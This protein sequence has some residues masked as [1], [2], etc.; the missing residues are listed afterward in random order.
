M[1]LKEPESTD[2]LLYYTRRTLGDKG[3]AVA[4]VYK[5]ECPKCHKARMGKPADEKGKVKI[6]AN[7]YVCPACGY[8]EDKKTHEESCILQVK[9][10]CP[11]CSKSGEAET[12]YKRTSFEGS[13]AYV[14]TCPH[15]MKKIGIT[16]KM[17]S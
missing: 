11:F 4:W 15:C 10:V 5:K 16:K 12:G 3:K 13:P 6:R 14:F 1:V 8:S 17:K 9:C 2:E 7:L